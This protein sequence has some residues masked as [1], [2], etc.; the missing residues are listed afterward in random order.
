METRFFQWIVGER[1]GEIVVLKDIVREEGE[2][3][4]TFR[5]DSR[6][7]AN[8]VAPI[9]L[10]DLTGKIMAEVESPNNVWRFEE[11]PEEK[12]RYEIDH[13]TQ[14]RYE[15]PSVEEIQ[16]HESNQPIKKKKKPIK[17]IPPVATNANTSPRPLVPSSESIH[18]VNVRSSQPAKVPQQA[19]KE[20]IQH[21]NDPVWLMMERAKKVDTEV[22]MAIT[23]SLP[24]KSLFN[25]ADESFDDGGQKVIEYI[26]SNLDDRK[27]KDSLRIALS[28]AYGKD[29]D[30]EV[31]PLV[32]EKKRDPLPW[33]G[34]EKNT[35]EV[36]PPMNE[37]E[38]M[39]NAEPAPPVMPLFEPEVV[40]EPVVG[41]PVEGP[42]DEENKS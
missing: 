39:K 37:K 21:S 32:E 33:K 24:T 27:L 38:F 22:E 3:F 7:N 4:L 42:S 16:A 18:E 12:P 14:K 6:I 25:V 10:R 5:D 20:V 29:L 8:L 26:I 30:S 34:D 15:I 2:I 35:E 19:P 13:E 41:P 1:R 23:I 36:K 28:Q 17:L 9:D 40:E 31:E 11:P